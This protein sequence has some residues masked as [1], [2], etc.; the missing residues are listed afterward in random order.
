MAILSRFNRDD[1]GAA[2]EVM[3]SL[4]DI[5]DG[6]PDDEE[7]GDLELTGDDRGDQ[8]WVEWHTMRGTQKRG[9]NVLAGQ[10]DDEDDDSDQGHD[11]GEPDF[12]HF[13]GHG[14]GCPIADPGGCQHDGREF[15]DGV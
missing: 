4:L 7:G 3:V 9:L 15:C 8:A 11:E 10:E 13:A 5:W 2:I 1:L 14:A 12:T 6:Q